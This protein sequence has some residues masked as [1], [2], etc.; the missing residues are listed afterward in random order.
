MS[1]VWSKSACDADTTAP[2]AGH[3]RA[4]PGPEGD[5][6]GDRPPGARDD[7]LFPGLDALD[8]P[9]EVR[10]SLVDVH[11]RFGHAREPTRLVQVSQLGRDGT[12]RWPTHPVLHKAGRSVRPTA[13]VEASCP[14][15]SAVAAIVCLVVVAACSAGAAAV[16]PSTAVPTVSPSASAPSPSAAPSTMAATPSADPVLPVITDADP[17][18]LYTTHRPDADVGVYLMRLDG[19]DA[20]QLATDVHGS[21]KHPDWSPDGQHVVFI[22]ETTEKMWIANLDGTPSTSITACDVPGCDYPAWSPDGS[23]LAFS[24]AE[25]G[26]GRRTIGRRDPRSG[27][28]VRGCVDRHSPRASAARRRPALVAG[29]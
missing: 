25:F 5:Q 9:R 14:D 22:D 20:V 7:D 27:S 2:L 4:R 24:R 11:G 13:R 15:T 19:T 26:A 1:S 10:L 21:L 6:A 8:E 18:I 28:G 16:A 17:R 29:R 3:A 23:K 12:W